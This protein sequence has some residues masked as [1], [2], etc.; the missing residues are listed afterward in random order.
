MAH[1]G[2]HQTSVGQPRE[3]VGRSVSRVRPVPTD[4]ADQIA[5]GG[6]IPFDRFMEL[7]LY[8]VDGFYTRAD[9]GSA[10]RRGD[11]ITSPEIGP[12][13]GA[14]MAR[15]LD[16]EWER[17]GRPNPFTVIDAGAGPGTLAR[18]IAAASPRCA[19]VMHYIAVEV[20]SAQ[21][22]RHPT[23]VTSS[24]EMPTAPIDG[25]IIANELLD[26]LTFRLAVYD[27]GWREAFV[28]I[29]RDGRLSERL[30]APFDPQPAQ[31]PASAPHGA[32]VQLIDTA[33]DFVDQAR[34]LL[35]SGS[36]LTIDYAVAVTSELA[37]R[38]WRDWLRTYR[39]Q[40]R[41]D[42]YLVDPGGQDITADVPIDQLP[43][44]DSV[45]RQE[46]FLKLRGIDELVDEGKRAWAEQAA[47]PGL[48]AMKMRSRISEAEALLDTSGLGGFLVVEWR[49]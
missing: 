19:D 4:I 32:R 10:G 13:F 35:R 37:H 1:H 7:A 26:N 12:L 41:G 2:A 15:H 6:P 17:I 8:G 39:G 3:C 48:E 25:V 24:A 33:R 34:A 16:A 23:Q 27:D 42:H 46:H 45:R 18:T 43:E 38:P 14:V 20:S 31:L 44:P 9:G 49:A 5:S 21:R 29:D 28:D 40:E 30:S 11:F 36:L 47:R 22:E